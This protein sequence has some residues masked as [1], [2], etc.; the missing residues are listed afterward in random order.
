M[1]R[2]ISLLTYLL[3]IVFL[4]GPAIANN[5]YPDN[6]YG[7]K[8]I[9]VSAS[10]SDAEIIVNGKIV[11]KGSAEVLV[12]KDDCVT[13]IAKKVGYLTESIE[14]C[15]QKRMSKPPKTYYFE[16]RNDNA[17]D[18]SVQ[19]DIANVDIEIKVDRMEKDQAWKLINQIVLNYIDIIEMTDK[20]TG[21]LR[22]AWS[23]QTFQQNT[24]RTRMIVKESSTNPLVFKVKLVSEE[25]GDTMTSVK[26]D[27]LFKE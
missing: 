12:P 1:K 15:N 9:Q 13:V 4:S 22:T 5:V 23:L 2:K 8:K 6:Y 11:G 10:Q 14:F 19:T 3:A 16:M 18:A 7:K 17:F 24:I 20:E 21:Y 27:H 25:S 26:S